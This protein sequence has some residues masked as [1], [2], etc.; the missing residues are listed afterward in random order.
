MIVS[1]S[2]MTVFLYN[3]EMRIEYGE[4]RN[5]DIKR[6]GIHMIN[7]S[8]VPQQSVTKNRPFLSGSITSLRNKFTLA[9][10]PALA[11][12]KVLELGLEREQVLPLKEQFV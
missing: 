3:T 1:T 5:F 10:A 2:N 12:G 4:N 6:L 8:S 9:L 7:L 11:R